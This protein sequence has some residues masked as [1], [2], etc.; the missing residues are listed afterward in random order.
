[1]EAR[2]EKAPVV[3]APTRYVSEPLS[4]A[5][6]REVRA[7]QRMGLLLPGSPQ[8][9]RVD[10]VLVCGTLAGFEIED[11]EMRVVV[12]LDPERA[13]AYHDRMRAEA[14]SLGVEWDGG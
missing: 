14:E 8:S 10:G 3:D 7:M 12:N 1:M 5:E 13:K 2:L 6:R 4:S 11:C 9:A